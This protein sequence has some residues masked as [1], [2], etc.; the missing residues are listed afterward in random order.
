M[1]AKRIQKARVTEAWKQGQD[2]EK[3]RDGD[4]Q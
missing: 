2:R 3:I 4:V 1:K